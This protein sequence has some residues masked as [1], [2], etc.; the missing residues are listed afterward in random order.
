[1]SAVGSQTAIGYQVQADQLYKLCTPGCAI[2]AE[3]AESISVEEASQTRF[4]RVGG[5]DGPIVSVAAL[6]LHTYGVV[7]SIEA[8][9]PGFIDDAYL[10]ALSIDTATPTLELAVAGLWRREEDGYR[11]RSS[12]TVRIAREVRRQLSEL[13]AVAAQRFAS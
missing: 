13:E 11:V 9:R 7:V 12:E 3:Q 8:G 2:T 10:D 1:M 5:T 4:V 6:K